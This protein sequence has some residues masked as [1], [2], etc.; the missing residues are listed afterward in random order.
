[1]RTIAIINQKGGCGKTTT[2]VNLAAVLARQ[3]KRTLLVDMDPQSHCAVGLGI[4]ENRIELD[5]GDAMLGIGNWAIDTTRLIWRAGRNLDL[6]PSRMRLAGLEARRGGLAEMPDKEQRLGKVL[7]ALSCEYDLACIDCPPSIGLLTFNALAIADMVIIPVETSFF[8]LQGATRQVNTVRTLARRLGVQI[9]VWMLPTIHDDS[10]PVACDLLNVMHQRFKDRVAPVVIRRD[11][12]LREAAS[13]GV[14]ILDYAANSQGAEDYGRLATWVID[15]IRER[16]AAPAEMAADAA[17]VEGS[18]TEAGYRPPEPESDA[19]TDDPYENDPGARPELEQDARLLGK[20]TIASPSL[21]PA[22]VEVVR[23]VAHA[24]P[25][26]DSL[27]DQLAGLVAGAQARQPVPA[28]APAGVVIPAEAAAAPEVKPISRAE[29]VARR[30]QQFLRKLAVGGPQA[31][32]A[33]PLAPVSDASA[34]ATL[35][36][37]EVAVIHPPRQV[38]Q[39]LARP[40]PVP[41]SASVSRVLGVRQTSQGVLFVQ[42]MSI[43]SKVAIA[44]SFNQWIPEQHVMRANPELGVYELCTK[45]PPGKILYRVVADGHWSADPYNE[46]CEPNPFGEINSVFVVVS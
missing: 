14:S 12:R 45:L 5:V 32:A 10:S 4:P 28:I 7:T 21:R 6:L 40:R 23:E 20:V 43:G 9:P 2:A 1:M 31:V 22:P 16:A 41:V 42:P 11:V 39:E 26:S 34:T 30:A 18:S 35:A 15:S 27:K 19:D 36:Q 24:E 44:G 46:A 8:S 25:R 37:P 38:L 17:E 13:Y 33:E 29:D 3:G